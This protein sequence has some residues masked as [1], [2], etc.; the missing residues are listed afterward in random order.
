[1]GYYVYCVSCKDPRV[2]MVRT[3]KKKLEC[4]DHN[5]KLYKREYKCPMCQDSRTFSESKD[6][7]V[8]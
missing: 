2:R 1:M 6:C 7:F 3:G 4:V 5:F 8:Q